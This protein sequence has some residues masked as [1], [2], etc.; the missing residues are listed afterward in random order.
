MRS[1]NAHHSAAFDVRNGGR[2]VVV[3]EAKVGVGSP[4]TLNRK[5][6]LRSIIDCMIHR[7]NQWLFFTNR[8][9]QRSRFVRKHS[10]GFRARLLTRMQTLMLI[11]AVVFF[12]DVTE[13]SKQRT[14]GC[15]TT[16]TGGSSIPRG[17]F[18]TE[19]HLR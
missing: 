4:R 10:V 8:T 12:F 19:L 2:V 18:D 14:C 1:R 13:A 11:S 9:I 17:A 5:G 7:R 16:C 6:R 3:V 15:T